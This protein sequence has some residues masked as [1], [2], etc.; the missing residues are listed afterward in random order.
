MR[1]GICFSD[2]FIVGDIPCF[3]YAELFDLTSFCLSR[4]VLRP[5]LLPCDG[6]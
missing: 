2:F 3:C 6:V 4:W 5:Y 1:E